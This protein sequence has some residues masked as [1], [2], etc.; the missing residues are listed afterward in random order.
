MLINIDTKY[1]KELLNYDSNDN[2]ESSIQST[3]K[4][5]SLV[6]GL[7][8]IIVFSI[9]IAPFLP[10]RIYRLWKLPDSFVAY[11]Q[12]IKNNLFLLS[13]IVLLVIIQTLYSYL[14]RQ[15]DNRLAYKLVGT[16][17]VTYSV[18]LLT[19]RLVILNNFHFLVLKISDK[20]FDIVEKNVVLRIERTATHKLISSQIL[21]GQASH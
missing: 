3:P 4:R 9:T 5:K 18:Y 16:F 15:L 19:R 10:T 2:V 12:S 17:K 20:D 21:E 7:I 13:L 11:S 6:L 1:N 8:L 14:R